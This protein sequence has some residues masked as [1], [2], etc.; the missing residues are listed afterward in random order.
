MRRL[1]SSQK[2]ERFLKQTNKRTIKP[3]I[4]KQNYTKEMIKKKNLR[5]QAPNW[6]VFAAC[7]NYFIRISIQ[8]KEPVVKSNSREKQAKGMNRNF[9]EQETRMASN[10]HEKM[11]KFISN[12]VNAD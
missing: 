7:I 4:D 12:Q 2:G 6:K 1:L 5:K 8:Y 10:L 9:T 3:K 11:C